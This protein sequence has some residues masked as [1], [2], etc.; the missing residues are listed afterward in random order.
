[1]GRSKGKRSNTRDLF[2]KPFRQHG[3]PLGSTYLTRFYV[4]DYVDIKVNSA[5]QKGMPHKF[6]VGKTARVFDVS[7]NSIGVI[8]NKVVGNRKIAKKIHVRRE[9]VFKS[10]CQ[11]A[12]KERVRQREKERR[13]ARARGEKLIHPKRQP[14]GPPE[15]HF[16]DAAGIHFVEPPPYEFVV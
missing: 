8:V 7:K 4:G 5:I 3:M 15:A 12:F 11:E 14:K 13:E 6:Y 1:M 9:H 16:V 2:S 10:R